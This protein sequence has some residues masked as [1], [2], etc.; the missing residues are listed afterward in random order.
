MNV[1]ILTTLSTEL[2]YLIAQVIESARNA[3]DEELHETINTLTR[4]VGLSNK[5]LATLRAEAARRAAVEEN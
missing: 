2:P 4:A 5:L 3:G 1:V